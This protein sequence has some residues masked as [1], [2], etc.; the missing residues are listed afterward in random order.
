MLLQG[1]P[2]V[3]TP[4][5]LKPQR[6]I[7]SDLQTIGA[8]LL[9]LIHRISANHT[10]IGCLWFMLHH[11]H[12]CSRLTY[13]TVTVETS[14]CRQY[15]VFACQ[16]YSDVDLQVLPPPSFCS[17]SVMIR[18]LDDSELSLSLHRSRTQ[19]SCLFALD[20]VPRQYISTDNNLNA[21]IECMIAFMKTPQRITDLCILFP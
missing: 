13:L 20:E 7:T 15:F 16:L 11:H 5:S 14:T 2:S 17:L 9:L 12:V 6:P 4:G 10:F 8:V 19:A 3:S 21:V 18:R 1:L